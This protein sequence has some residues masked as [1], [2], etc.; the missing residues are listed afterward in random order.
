MDIAICLELEP[1]L[2]GTLE[3][4]LRAVQVQV[5]RPCASEGRAVEP[6]L[7]PVV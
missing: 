4:E 3:L 5:C 2:V 6:R 7:L 1:E